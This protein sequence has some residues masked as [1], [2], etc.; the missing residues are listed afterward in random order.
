MTSTTTED[1]DLRDSLRSIEDRMI[2]HEVPGAATSTEHKAKR[3]QITRAL[4]SDDPRAHLVEVARENVSGM[5]VADIQAA[6]SLCDEMRVD[7]R[8]DLSVGDKTENGTVI[9]ATE[10]RLHSDD[11]RAIVVTRDRGPDHNRRYVTHVFNPCNGGYFHG[12]YT[13]DATEA[14]ESHDAKVGRHH[15]DDIHGPHPEL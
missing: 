7:W 2:D 10:L 14:M 13:A 8:I 15:R 1:S 9:R 5:E 3:E 6:R 11:G 12:D 4:D